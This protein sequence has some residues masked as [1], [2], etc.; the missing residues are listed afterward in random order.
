M[1]HFVYFYLISISTLGYGFLF[2]NIFDIKTKNEGII[3]ISGIFFSY[4]H[5]LFF[6][7]FFCARL[8]F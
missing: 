3:G 4:F 2:S 5:L 7:H 1:L 8:F 6:N